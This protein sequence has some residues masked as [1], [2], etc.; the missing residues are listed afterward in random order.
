VDLRFEGEV[1]LVTGGSSGIGRATA[2]A[3]A[4]RGARVVIASRRPEESAETVQLIATAGGEALF[5]KTDVTQAA[6]VEAL[7]ASTLANFGRL[8]YAVNSAGVGS[9]PFVLTEDYP[10]ETWDS[11]IDSNLKGTFLC[12]KY[13]LPPI[14]RSKG[15]IVNIASVAGLRGGRLGLAYYASKHGVVGITKAAALEYAD[16]GVRINAVAPAVIETPMSQWAIAGDSMQLA[17]V[18]QTHPLGR[19]GNSDEVAQAAVW[20]CSRAASFTTGHILAVDGGRLAQ[21]ESPK[22]APSARPAP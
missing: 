8:D 13:E 5:V 2:L 4:R 12:M 3:F 19:I 6:Q 16:T 18:I 22:A 17:R 7:V 10:E 11:V 1:A 20:L 21:S 14:V 9:P 15:A